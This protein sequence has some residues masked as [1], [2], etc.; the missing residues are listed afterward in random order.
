MPK[1]KQFYK[2]YVPFHNNYECIYTCD[3]AFLI[4]TNESVRDNEEADPENLIKNKVH[5]ENDTDQL[6][7]ATIKE[8]HHYQ[9]HQNFSAV[10]I[11]PW[12]NFLK[13]NRTCG[14]L[15]K[16]PT[17]T[18]SSWVK[19][20]LPEF[21]FDWITTDPKLRFPADWKD[22][23]APQPQNKQPQQHQPLL[24]QPNPPQLQVEPST[25]PQ[26]QATTTPTATLACARVLR[27]RPPFDYK[28]LHTGIKRKCKSLRRKAQAVVTKLAPGAF[29]PRRDGNGD[30]PSTSTSAS[31]Q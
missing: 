26:P 23:I 5:Q 11:S 19:R 14:I 10:N 21:Q 16:T 2:H 25:Q 18:N 20:I 9:L 30:G 1:L 24:P 7:I 6:E 22:L 31:Q 28:E 27:N 29:S 12:I 15:T 4:N 8:S 3:G 13:K 17:S